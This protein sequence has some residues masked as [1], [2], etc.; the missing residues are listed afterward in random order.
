VQPETGAAE[1]K[2]HLRKEPLLGV[3]GVSCADPRIIS[4]KESLEIIPDGC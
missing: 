1:N 2:P 3:M 4:V